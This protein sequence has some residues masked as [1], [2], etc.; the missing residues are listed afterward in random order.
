MSPIEL[1]AIDAEAEA[2]RL[3]AEALRAMQLEDQSN[4]LYDTATDALEAHERARDRARQARTLADH[5]SGAYNAWS[6]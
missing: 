5:Y 2:E 6:A 4:V 1:A 3:K